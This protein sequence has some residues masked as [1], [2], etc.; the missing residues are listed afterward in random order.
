MNDTPTEKR[1]IPVHIASAADG[2]SLG[3]V[4]ATGKRRRQHAAL[5]DTILFVATE[6]AQSIL[7]QSDT[8]EIAYVIALDGAVVIGSSKSDAAAGVGT[9]VPQN[10]RWPVIDDRPV[11][12]AP[13]PALTAGTTARLS[14]EAIYEESD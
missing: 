5:Y 8:R 11:Y 2:V 9:T 3:A 12:A 7:P 10:V 13:T 6:P 1:S 14:V 4:G